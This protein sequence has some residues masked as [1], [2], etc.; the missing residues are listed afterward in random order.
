MELKFEGWAKISL[1]IQVVF[2]AIYNPD[3]QSVRN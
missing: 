3:K 2:D 1:P